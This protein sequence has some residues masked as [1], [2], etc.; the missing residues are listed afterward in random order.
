M[1]LMLIVGK[2]DVQRWDFIQWHTVRAK[3]RE[4]LLILKDAKE[5]R[6]YAVRR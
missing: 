2:F 4:N 6:G 1:L 3:F 5:V